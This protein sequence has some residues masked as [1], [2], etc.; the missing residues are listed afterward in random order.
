M[1]ISSQVRLYNESDLKRDFLESYPEKT[2]YSYSFVFDKSYTLESHLKKD[3]YNFTTQEI[4]QVLKGAGYS[5]LNSVERDFWVIDKYLDFAANKGK[6]NSTIKVTKNIDREVLTSCVDKSNKTLWSENEINEIVDNLV[7]YQDKAL[8][9]ALFDGISGNDTGFTEL[10]NLKKSDI[11]NIG[12]DKK[13]KV[14]NGK[15]NI[16]R[17]VQLSDKTAS[18]LRSAAMEDVYI[19]KNGESE[20]KYG[21][22]KAL[23]ESDYIFR[24]VR[25]GKSASDSTTEPASKLFVSRK[26]GSIGTWLDIRNFNAKNVRNSGMLK[27]AKDLY[28]RDGEL[29]TKQLAE[30]AEHY[31]IQKTNVGGHLVYV[32]APLKQFITIDN[33]KSLYSEEI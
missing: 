16:E 5:T 22:E 12:E 28:K 19:M 11:H 20:T 3:L 7:N 1:N 9:M 29:E 32:F 10:L 31:G 6:I 24:I 21:G 23:V 25:A 27:M 30:I 4:I 8:I 14:H 33:I 26:F 13:I 17:Y 18:Y 2:Q 15:L